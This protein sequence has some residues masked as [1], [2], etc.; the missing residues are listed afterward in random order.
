MDDVDLSEKLVS[1][2]DAAFERENTVLRGGASEPFYQPGMPSVIY[3]RE[4][5]G[6]SALHEVAHWC[7][8]GKYR[9]TLDDYGYW[10]APDGRNPRQQAAFYGVEVRPQALE[11]VFCEALSIPFQVSV[12]NLSITLSDPAISHFARAVDAE[13][14]RLRISGLPVRGAVFLEALET[15]TCEA[16][17]L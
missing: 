7:V 5:F 10:Y 9:R 1:L 12:D 17:G 8:A 15:M 16:H 3:F 2:F 4:N 6:R 11:R 14:R 13:R